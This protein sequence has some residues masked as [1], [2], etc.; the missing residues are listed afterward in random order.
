MNLPVALP[1]LLSAA[2]KRGVSFRLL[3]AMILIESA[4][5]GMAV[6]SKGEMG[7]GQFDQRTA[8]MLGLDDPFD[9]RKAADAAARYLGDLIRRFKSV[10]LALA[11]YNAGPGAVRRSGG[12]PPYRITRKYVADILR[13]AGLAGYR[14][15]V[16]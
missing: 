3:A 12:I 6:G 11:A 16:G 4:Y 9:T 7:L 5:D 13:Y 2:K 10:P 8:E 1:A 14:P 15:R